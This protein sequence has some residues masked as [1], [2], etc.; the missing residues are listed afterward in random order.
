[1][2]KDHGMG[3]LPWG[4]RVGPVKSQVSSEEG[5]RRVSGRDRSRVWSDA[6]AVKGRKPRNVGASRSFKRTRNRFSPWR[7]QVLKMEPSMG[8]RQEET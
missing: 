6:I 2:R 8:K 5:G 1:M 7:L 4:I 3:R